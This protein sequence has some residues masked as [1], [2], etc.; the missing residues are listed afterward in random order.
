MCLS[1]F[2]FLPIEISLSS[3][4][5]VRSPLIELDGTSF[6]SI[7]GTGEGAC[8]GEVGRVVTFVLSKAGELDTGFSNF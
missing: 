6:L 1:N 2:I 8:F 5:G 3:E 7:D 4:I